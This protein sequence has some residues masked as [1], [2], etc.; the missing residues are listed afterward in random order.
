M[1]RGAPG[2]T[3]K[4][5]SGTFSFLLWCLPLF[6]SFAKLFISPWCC[7]KETIMDAKQRVTHIPPLPSFHFLK[8]VLVC[9]EGTRCTHLLT[10]SVWGGSCRTSDYVMWLCCDQILWINVSGTEWSPASAH[11]LKTSFTLWFLWLCLHMLTLWMLYVYFS[12]L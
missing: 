2:G 12:D 4:A 5:E 3:Q 10:A 9:P 1:T 7:C 6:Q 11:S 8:S